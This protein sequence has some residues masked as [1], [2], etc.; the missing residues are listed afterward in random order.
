MEDFDTIREF[1][2]ESNENLGRL[3]QEIVELE[4][5]PGN[6]ELVASIFRTIHTIKGTCGFLGFDKL[7]GV[8]HSAENIL[9]QVR[10]GKRKASNSL[11]SIILEA[12]DA[13]KEILE[14]IERT[15]A[16]GDN[17]FEELKERLHSFS[18][19][20]EET[21][22]NYVKKRTPASSAA[23]TDLLGA[24]AET[25]PKEASLGQP[26]GAQLEDE[27]DLETS[28]LMKA[29]LGNDELAAE[30]AALERAVEA[31][32]IEEADH[33][34][35]IASVPNVQAEAVAAV[36][37]QAEQ[38]ITMSGHTNNPE[39]NASLSEVRGGSPPPNI[40]RVSPQPSAASAPAVVTELAPLPKAAAAG[41]GAE[42]GERSGAKNNAVLDSTIRVD[43]GLLDKLMNLVGELVLARNQVLQFTAKLEAGT[44]NATSQRLNLI[45]SELQENVMKT[46]MQPIGIVWG[47]FPRV[48]RDLAAECGKYIHLTMDGAETELDRTIIEAIKDPL[49]HIVRNSCDHGIERPDERIKN[50]KTATGHLTLRAFH[51]GG[52][53]NI[54]ISDDGGGINPERIKAKAVQKGLLSAEQAQRLTE[55][56]A[57]N[58]IFLAGF[59]T[60]D[61]VSN[62]SGRGVGMDVVKTNIE[63]IGGV[64]DL[65]SI[66][67]HGT[68]IKI[69]IPL[70]LAIIPGLVITGAGQRFVI[71]QVSLFELIRLEGESGMRQIERIHGT[72]VYRRRGKLLPLTFLNEILKVPGD[73]SESDVVNI[74][75]LQAEDSEFG[76]VVD[77]I[78]DT[79]EIVVKPLGKR[80]KGLSMYSGATIMGDGKVALILDVLGIAQRSGVLRESREVRSAN[81]EKKHDQGMKD[82]QSMLLFSAGKFERLA[83]PLS[84]V[85]RLEE[86]PTSQVEHAAG[87]MVVQ[88]RGQIL[89]LVSLA[90]QLDPGS[91]TPLPKDQNVQV[92]VFSNGDRLIG[93]VVDR[94]LDIVEEH[95]TVRKSS[96]TFGLMGS[97]VVGQKVTD[98]VDLTEIIANSGEKWAAGHKSVMGGATV[99]VVEKSP[100]A[101]AHLRSSLEMA[102]YRVVEASGFQDAVDKLSREKIRIVAA[103]P[104]FSELAQHIKGNPKLANI[105]LLG[106]LAE[107]GSPHNHPRSELFEDFQMKF[108]RKAML[109]SLERLAEAV[110]QSEQELVG[111]S[112]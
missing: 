108:D 69:K 94:I 73:K 83:V 64:V 104:E 24:V 31:K 81:K 5:D 14:V 53:V 17:A 100:F 93:L 62:I 23:A 20:G 77:G 41:S 1:L 40:E 15:S 52:H 95:V 99:M 25:H 47:K 61:K 106:L 30:A 80:L 82:R 75:V 3:D 90:G 70:T 13:T 12:V 84:L 28:I 97:A 45:T 9:S 66:D 72:P 103:S 35:K 56:E 2:I 60:S 50:G 54:E 48:V 11:I 38:G 59:S 67:G 76:L 42:A 57:L 109:S 74:V 4:K 22:A 91:E 43:V 71:P 87:R 29:L 110:E 98:F 85:A 37:E 107:G 79:Q 58:L 65:L 96:D 10:E 46:R 88:Y 63:R 18:E 19:A 78:N 27:I 39:V 21:E 68:T 92:V 49:T 34:F 32:T 8:T 7:T 51:E 26:S 112:R 36:S 105:K 111:A 86:I 44:F 6:R 102:G 33:E 16:E 89:P 55:R 101:R